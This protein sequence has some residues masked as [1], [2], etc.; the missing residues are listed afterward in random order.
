MNR[1]A[2]RSGLAYS[3]LYIAFKLVILLGGYSLTRF[4]YF[5]SNLTAALLIIPFYYITVKQSRDADGNGV[6]G[7]KNAM[8]LCLTVFAIAAVL[9]S[10]YNYFE[11]V[12]GGQQLAI[13][14][15]H[16][17]QFL[18]FLNK[19]WKIKPEDYTRIIEEQVKGAEG[20]AFRATTGKLFSLLLVGLTGAF[21]V[22]S[23]MK[24]N[25]RN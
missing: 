1:R 19:Q 16:G 12:Y 2:L 13:D 3:A 7:G 20:A 11:Y 15:Y 24:R 18:E 23:L 5:Y 17:P 10:V 14:Y 9:T 4:G 21:A 22:A 25:P 6:I 8:R